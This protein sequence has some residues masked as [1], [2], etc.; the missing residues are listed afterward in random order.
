[1]QRL[2]FTH[3]VTASPS[4]LLS[5]EW[6]SGLD[7]GNSTFFAFLHLNSFRT[8]TTSG[9][10]SPALRIVMVSPICKSSFI[11][12]SALC[13]VALLTVVPAKEIG[14]NSATGVIAPVRPT[15]Q[16]NLINLL[17]AS[18]AGNLRAIAHF[19]AFWVNPIHF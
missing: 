11:N 17:G 15:W 13:N 12:R 1:M 19:G 16:V 3:F 10:I 18:A 5:R 9:I 7:S 8:L 14:S 2:L 6:H 4:S